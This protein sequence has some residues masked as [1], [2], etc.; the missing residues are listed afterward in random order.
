MIALGRLNFQL[1]TIP[2][3]FRNQ[4]AAGS[5]P[6]GGSNPFKKKGT[7]EIRRNTRPEDDTQQLE[8]SSSFIYNQLQVCHRWTCSPPDRIETGSGRYSLRWQ[9]FTGHWA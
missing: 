8:V 7:Y 9:I 2:R 3:V 4:Q 6:A 5:I 1:F